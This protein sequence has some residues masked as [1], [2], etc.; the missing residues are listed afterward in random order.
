MCGFAGFIDFGKELDEPQRLLKHMADTLVHRGPDD[1]GIWCDKDSGIGLAHRRL[2]IVDL[3]PE[4]HQPMI[5]HSGRYVIAY[6]GEIYNF[7]DIRRELDNAQRKIAWRGTS[8]T[9]VALEAISH[10]GVE[11]AVKKFNGMFAFALWDMN[12]RMLHLARD[13]FGEKPLYYGWAGNH[14]LFGSELKALRVHPNFQHEIDRNSV[15]LFMRY[16]YIPAPHS[17]YTNIYKLMPASL[18]TI[19]ADAEST[20]DPDRI[21]PRAYWSPKEVAECGVDSQLDC[22]LEEAINQLD[23]LFKRA[24]EMR[25]LADVPLGAFLSGG[26][27]SSAVV[28]MMQAHSDRPVRTFSIG[29][30]IDDYNEAPFAKDVAKHLGTDH[31][32][33]YVTPAETLAVI[34]KLPNIYDE[35]FADSSQ[36]PTTLLSQ[37]TRDHVTVSLSG[38]GGDE[39]FGGYN[40]HFLGRTIWNR[41]QRIP[42]PARKLLGKLLNAARPATVDRLHSVAS[43][44]LPKM[45]MRHG[46]PGRALEKIASII[47]A[48]APEQMYQALASTWKEPESLVLNAVE[49][50]TAVM[51]T[52][53]WPKLN[54]IANQ[55]MCMDII[56]Y[57]PDDI[58]AK[59]DRA[60]MSTSL[61]TRMPFL[62]P[63]LME[64]AWQIPLEWKIRGDEGKW[65]LRQL[66]YRY[67][68]RELVDRPKKGFG[69]PI[70]E[71]L[72]GPLRD[73]A[74]SLINEQRLADE[75]FLDL[76]TVIRCWRQHLAEKRFMPAKLWNVLMF[77]A[78]LESTR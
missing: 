65:I 44:V 7:P 21:A 64:F 1:Q 31:T 57:L 69:V 14:L 42:K 71:W 29:S 73:W 28:A 37:L 75:M 26:I 34:P 47:A 58:L 4:G 30:S 70:G 51:K 2:S 52:E 39:L 35:P 36:I 48:E 6:N 15:A 25:M 45:M 49:A 74:E 38:D 32:E 66:V 24:V 78:W 8:D 10:W 16:S 12:K 40:R 22:S 55:M 62:D 50:P 43:H 19:S 20:P 76:E 77:Q 9:E 67:V 54:D 61:E 33:L 59:V 60:S 46:P 23:R 56:T 53:S 41:A 3:S 17:I 68:P 13:R 72:R 63:N 18:L 27:D 5:S 11:E